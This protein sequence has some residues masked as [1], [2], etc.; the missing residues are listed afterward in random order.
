M[1]SV[2]DYVVKVND[3]VCR[4]EEVTHLQ[5]SGVSSD[6]LYYLLVPINNSG[7][8]IFV[9]VE[10]RESEL[11]FVVKK[12]RIDEIVSQIPNMDAEWIVNNKFR[13]I[14][15]KEVLHSGDIEQML[16]YIKIILLKRREREIEGKKH[17]ALD[18]RYLKMMEDAVY[19]E[20]AFSLGCDRSEVKEKILNVIM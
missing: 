9:P 1:Y 12:D 6:K 17:T 5:M 13:E 4:V 11:R 15:Y 14:K 10:G 20:L 8:R 3:G 18:E 7:S 16:T 19:A 2:G